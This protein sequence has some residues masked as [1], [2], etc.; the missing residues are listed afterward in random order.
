MTRQTWTAVA[1]A[2]IFVLAATLIAFVPIPFVA[3]TPGLTYDLLGAGS[4]GKPL[5]R[6]EGVETYPTKGELRLTTVSQ[7]RADSNLSLPE[8]ML[9]YLLPKRDVLPRSAVY[10]AGKT[11]V[12][13]A[14]EEKQLMSTAQSQAVVAALRAADQPVRELPMVTSVRISGPS[15]D[16]LEPGDLITSVDNSSVLSSADVVD[17]IR[18]KGVGQKVVLGVLRGSAPMSVTI[19]TVG[20]SSDGRVATIGVTIGTGYSYGPTV[21][22]AIDP[23]IGGGSGGLIFSLAIYDKI[24]P[25]SL[26]DGRNIAGTGTIDASGRVGPIGAIQEKIAGAEAE[27]ATVFLVPESNCT[28][29]VGV[30]THMRLVKVTTLYDAIT[31]LRSLDDP[32]KDA[33]VPRC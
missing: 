18:A 27:G 6:V 25:D 23:A 15:N 20:A 2:L 26:I 1:S 30:S 5:V 29:T 4:D 17:R 28:D 22:Y 9:N 24:T 12:Q 16:K 19:D 13:V 3:W 14:D 31:S 33:Q 10:D 8:A 21:T 11:P 7:T 32:S